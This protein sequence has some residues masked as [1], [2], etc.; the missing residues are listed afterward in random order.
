MLFA[1]LKQF[2]FILKKSFQQF[3][4]EG[5]MSQ[6]AALTY[7]SLLSLVPLLSVSFVI[8]SA[9][10]LFKNIGVQIQDFIFI[11][12]VATSGQ[13]IETY[14]THFVD[15]TKNLSAIGFL[16]LFLVAILMMFNLEQ[17]F[18]AIWHVPS[19]K[20]GIPVFLLYWAILT[21][22]PIILSLSLLLSHYVYTLPWINFV[23]NKTGGNGLFQFF[24]P[25]ILIW[26]LF[27]ILYLGVPNDKV[28]FWP[29]FISAF[30]T[31]LLF[32]LAKYLFALYIHYFTSYVM[33]YGALATIPIFLIWLYTT[34]LIILFGA[35]LTYRLTLKETI[36]SSVKSPELPSALREIA[37]FWLAFK[38]GKILSITDLN[39][40]AQDDFQRSPSEWLELFLAK[41]WLHQ[42]DEHH[43][44]LAKDISSLTLEQFSQMF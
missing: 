2:F 8:I 41:G 39:R 22:A 32:N 30:V 23:L 26:A 7:T 19:R 15:Q 21:L 34:W 25:F 9:F 11:H 37:Y 35:V 27:I 3:L 6:A 14:L 16:S 18:N 1:S 33:I 42:I 13:T 29:C 4:A 36:T 28:P 44:V 10:P 43:Y 12:F 20:K 17:S 5:C 24:L 40:Y 31:A 38:E